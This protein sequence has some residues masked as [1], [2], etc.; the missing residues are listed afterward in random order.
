VEKSKEEK[1]TGRH[2]VYVTDKIGSCKECIR[3]MMQRHFQA[4]TDYGKKD[5]HIYCNT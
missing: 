5:R 4:I 3:R 2:F 1:G